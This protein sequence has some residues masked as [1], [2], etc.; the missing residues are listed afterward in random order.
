MTNCRTPVSIVIPTYNRAN[1]LPRAVHSVVRQ[2]TDRDEIIIVDDGSSDDT[3]GCLEPFRH[4]IHYIRVPNGG[5]GRARNIGVRQARN[6]YVAF[7]DSDDE[8]MPGKLDLQCGLMDARPEIL[9][10]FSNTGVRFSWGTEIHR[11][12]THRYKDARVGER[13]LGNGVPF[14]ALAE[15]PRGRGDFPVHIGSLY[16]AEMGASHVLTSSL[17]VRREDAGDALRFAEDLPTYEDWECFGRLARQGPA[18]YLDC[19]TTWFY[20]HEGPQ[21]TD[22]NASTAASA[23]IAVLTRIWGQDSDYLTDHGE[24]YRRVLREQRMILIRNF[25]VLAQPREARKQLRE[26]SDAPFFY[27]FLAGMPAPVLR[28]LIKALR[29]VKNNVSE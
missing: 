28:G 19:D 15:L 27:S 29:M 21:L 6:E 9:F 5:A 14:S 12:L 1:V 10:C 4:R 2:C 20:S 7:L 23:R 17:M 18:A 24:D 26:L 13:M 8:W 22:A 11:Y 16:V 3:E 25:L